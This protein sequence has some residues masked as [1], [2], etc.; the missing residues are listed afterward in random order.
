ME[1]SSVKSSTSVKSFAEYK[2]AKGKQ[3]FSKVK[4]GKGKGTKTSAAD[5]EVLIYIGLLE[6][7]GKENVLKPK[8]GKKVALRITTSAKSSLVRQ[9]AEEKWKAYYR[10]L[11]E[12]SPTYLLLYEDGQQV[13]FLPGTSELF[14]L[15]RYQEEIGKDYNRI[16][17]YLCT[18]EDYNNTVDD[19][20]ESEDEETS[21]SA[22]KYAKVENETALTKVGE[23]IQQDEQL[24]RELE[25]QF[26]QEVW[27]DQ[28][29]IENVAVQK[30]S[31]SLV[32][33]ETGAEQSTSETI[34]TD[35]FSVVKKLSTRVDNTGQFFMVVR[36]ASSFT[37]RLNLWQRESKRTSPEKCLRVHFTGEDGIDSGAMSK[38]FLA[39]AILDM[40]SYFAGGGV[41]FHLEEGV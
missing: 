20:D 19:G 27:Q 34:L 3:W 21:P 1:S 36:R 18:T 26:N 38:E 41:R 35:H 33:Q 5:Q 40:G 4:G 31:D 24:A 6:W 2:T 11:Y 37:R 17:L 14:S 15:K 25:N 23:Q 32:Q 30:M 12:E 22:S 10:N 28:Q 7:N 29:I 9:K 16:H 8:R 39:Q 13:L